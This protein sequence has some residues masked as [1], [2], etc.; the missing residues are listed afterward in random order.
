MPRTVQEPA[1]VGRVLM[2]A[3]ARNS[4]YRVARFRY[5]FCQAVKAS[6][7]KPHVQEVE[8]EVVPPDRKHPGTSEI[9]SAIGGIAHVMDSLFPAPVT[10]FPFASNPL[11]TFIP[12]VF[13]QTP[14]LCP[15]P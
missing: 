8:V 12:L 7:H 13:H 1:V 15:H 2:G 5:S 9:D 11:F 6:E 3:A 10:T 14:P 4:P